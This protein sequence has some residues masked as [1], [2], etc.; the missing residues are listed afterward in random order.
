MALNLGIPGCG[1]GIAGGGGVVLRFLAHCIEL[2][3]GAV[4]EGG[5]LVAHGAIDGAHCCK[6]G[7]GY[8]NA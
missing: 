5:F 4:V 1:A 3:A 7:C 2:A 6:N 8:D